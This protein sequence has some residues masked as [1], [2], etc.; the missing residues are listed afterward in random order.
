[1][2]RVKNGLFELVDCS[3][4]LVAIL[5]RYARFCYPLPA[6]SLVCLS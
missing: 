2:K 1:M 4:W 3:V 6:T 5:S